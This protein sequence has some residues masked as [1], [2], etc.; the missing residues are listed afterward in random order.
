VNT[1]KYLNVKGIGYF[2]GFTA[3]TYSVSIVCDRLVSNFSLVLRLMVIVLLFI[4]MYLLAKVFYGNPFKQVCSASFYDSL[5]HVLAFLFFGYVPSVIVIAIMGEKQL[6][7]NAKPSFI[8][9]RSL[10]I[11]GYALIYWGLIG[12]MVAYFYH[13]TT[14]NLFGVKSRLAGVVAATLLFSVNYN[15]PFISG[16]WNVWDML[17]FGLVFAYSYS[18]KSNPF[19]LVFAYLMSEV[20]LW[21]CILAPFGDRVFSSY[22]LVRFFV[23]LIA[24]VIFVKSR[25]TGEKKTR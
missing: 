8:D 11:P 20:P 4:I 12:V 6:Y 21:W 18:V 10:H 14:Y 5:L 23:S 16:Y 13:A 24:F 1:T 2:V 15:T 19:A 9:E 22:F 25:K 7:L 3:V 17:F